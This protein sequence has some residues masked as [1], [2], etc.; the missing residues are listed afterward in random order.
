MTD[1]LTPA[2]PIRLTPAASLRFPD[3]AG[4]VGV[5]EQIDGAFV[6][7]RFGADDWTV[8]IAAEGVERC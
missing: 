2:T 1:A 7:L 3:L 4:R 5:V 6:V 8:R